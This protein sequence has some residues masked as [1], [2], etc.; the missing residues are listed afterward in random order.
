MSRRRHFAPLLIACAVA[1]GLVTSISASAATE[2]RVTVLA[3]ASLT[4]AF[5]S[6]GAAFESAHLGLTAEFSFAGSST[7]VAQIKEGSPGD[8]FASADESNMQAAAD[9]GELAGAPRIFA[10]NRLTI[11]VQKGNAKHIAALADLG[12]SGLSIA[13]AAPEVP[14]GKYAA[15]IFANAGVAVPQA[16][17][18]VDVRAVL[19]RVS[20]GEADAGIVYV[21]DLHAAG[22]TVEAVVIPDQFN[23]MARYPIAVLK[24]ASHPKEAAAFADFVLSPAGQTILKQFG[25]LAP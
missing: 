3:A 10:T 6:I 16:S 15:Q 14:A 11:V 7:L 19:T 18:E 9:A 1:S 21:T 24:Q 4:E 17:Q 12:R 8:V 13:L 23:V 2:Q 5:K 20:M 25:F 22:D